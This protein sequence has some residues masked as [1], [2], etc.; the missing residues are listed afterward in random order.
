MIRKPFKYVCFAA[1]KKGRS[2]LM[3]V[4]S[5]LR[6]PLPA[7]PSALR[8]R[9]NHTWSVKFDSVYRCSVVRM[10]VCHLA[11]K[12]EVQIKVG[13]RW[14]LSQQIQ[15]LLFPLL[16]CRQGIR[17]F[18]SYIRRTFRRRNNDE[19]H[20]SCSSESNNGATGASVLWF[21]LINVLN[22]AIWL[23]YPQRC[24]LESPIFMWWKVDLPN[25]MDF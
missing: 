15:S 18:W 23:K 12:S 10:L 13:T 7:A 8:S 2:L 5:L 17:D 4:W 6:E 20:F 11:S 16:K 3:E 9:I 24:S 14:W 1:L 19:I 21:K 25:Q 22:N